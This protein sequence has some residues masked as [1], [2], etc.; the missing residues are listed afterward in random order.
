MVAEKKDIL[1]ELVR[2]SSLVASEADFKS[3]AGTLVE[4]SID[5]SGSELAG[6]YAYT[7]PEDPSKGLRLLYRRGRHTLPVSLAGGLEWHRF[8]L[9]C[10]ETIILN[11]PRESPFAGLLLAEGMKSAIALPLMT[12]K[13]TIGVLILNSHTTDFYDRRRFHFL[14]SLCKLAAGMM[15][16]ARLFQE[17]KDYLKQIEDLERYQ[18]NI[19]ASMTNLLV[20]TDE[21]D[22]VEYFN[23]KAAA[24]FGLSEA[25]LGQPLSELFKGSL[26]QKLQKSVFAVRGSNQEILGLEG[27]WKNAEREMDFSLNVSPLQG[28]RGK[29]EGLTLLFTDQSREQELKQQM[30]QAVEERRQIKDM[31]SRYMS[32]EVVQSLMD[33]PESIKL[34]GDKKQATVFFA[35]IRGYTSFSEGKEPEYIVEVLNEYFTEAV[36]IVVQHRGYIDKFIGDCI[37]AAWGVPMTSEEEDALQ[38]VSCAWEIQQLIANPK[39]SFF[40]GLADHLRVGIGMHTGPLVAGNLGSNRRMDY[41]VIGDTVNIAARLEGQA[42]ADEVIITENT[43]SL[44]G[45]AFRLETREPVKVKGKEQLI[46]IYKVLGR[47]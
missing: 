27:I 22:C 7:D 43:R 21:R 30:H 45:G 5:V 16:N 9:D 34:G 6:L 41:S 8:L 36:E 13:L 26:D 40:K 4:Q 44:L 3:L 39:R 35:D 33:N 24:T 20:T 17:M 37:M 31:F 29:Y 11:Q 2:A 12:P 1:D 38:A 10:R 14:N 47:S 18:A 32:H 25:S 23:D 46:Q 19:F 15:H 28:K 42:K